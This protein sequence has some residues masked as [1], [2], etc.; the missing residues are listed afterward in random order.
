MSVDKLQKKIRKLKNPS[1]I[2]LTI[3]AESIPPCLKEREGSDLKA[4]SVF[5][6][7][8][9]ESLRGIVPAVRFSLCA[10]AQI[11][12]EAIAVLQD[13]MQT[14]QQLDYY[15]LLD[16]P[17]ALSA[18]SAETTAQ[19]LSN[20]PCDGFIISAYIG[21]DAIKAY[22]PVLEQKGK[23]LFVVLRTANR[24]ASELQELMTG[25]RLVYMAAADIVSRLGESLIGKCGYSQ[26]AGVGAA[27]ASDSLR[28]LRSKYNRL[29]L[30]LDGYDYSNANAKCCSY[31]FDQF[32][33]GAAVCAAD[34]VTAAWKQTPGD[35]SSFSTDAVEAAQ[36]MQKN[37]LR[38]ITVL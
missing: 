30:L 27:N 32:G 23:S 5:C 18:R 10:F 16:A 28:T 34:S 6:K 35:G 12:P 3:L 37:L 26:L 8:L 17:E 38:Y 25:S 13:M 20:W 11:G 22:L 4:Y 36:R 14:A 29:F 24:S 33:H 15:V 19:N 21:S 1:V 9:L 2:D 7:E 31:A